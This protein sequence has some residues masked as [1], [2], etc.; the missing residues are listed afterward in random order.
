VSPVLD[1][2]E[3]VL[4]VQLQDRREIDRRE[5][6]LAGVPLLAK[7]DALTCQ[8]VDVVLCGAISRV[9][10]ALLEVR[11]VRVLAW[12]A[13]DCEEVLR[14]LCL[15]RDVRELAVPPGCESA[16]EDA[17]RA[18]L[19]TC[20]ALE[21]LPQVERRCTCSRCGAQCAAPPGV[22]CTR[23]RCPRCGA[24]MLHGVLPDWRP[25]D[26]GAPT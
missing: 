9:L 26:Q 12:V 23:R 19:W 4:L 8:E 3:R 14:A 20:C 5:C 24:S 16:R 21:L 13:G 18:R 22:P 7:A 15:R 1:W 2:A 10:L 25:P 17:N 11:Q 6:R